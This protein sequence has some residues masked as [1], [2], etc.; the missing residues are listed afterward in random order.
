MLE[1]GVEK[2]ESSYILGGNGNWYNHYGKQKTEYRTTIRSSNPI[3]GHISGQYYNS[4]NLYVHC[5]TIHNSQDMET[6]KISI[7]R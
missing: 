5:S 2:R 3:L 1:K 4:V 7:K 6:T